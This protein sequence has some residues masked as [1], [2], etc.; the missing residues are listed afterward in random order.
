MSAFTNSQPSP[1]HLPGVA[2]RPTGGIHGAAAGTDAKGETI[3]SPHVGQNCTSGFTWVPHLWQNISFHTEYA[4]PW[5]Q[6]EKS[7]ALTRS[8]R[9]RAP[10]RHRRIPRPARE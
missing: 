10:G 8:S 7:G 4:I 6:F 5:K 2:L 1:I 9:R 3:A